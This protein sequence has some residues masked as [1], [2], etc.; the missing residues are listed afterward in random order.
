MTAAVAAYA[1]GW[2][3]AGSDAVEAQRP[4][5]AYAAHELRGSIALQRS[6]AEVALADPD[7]DTAALR[8]MGERVVAACERQERLLEALLTLSRSGRGLR[9]EPLDLAETAAEVLR[10]HDH[11]GLRRTTTLEPARTTGDP[12]L[13]ERLVANLVA[14]AVA[15][16]VPGGRLDVATHTAAGRAVF[17]IANTGPPIPTREL[18]RLFQPFQQLDSQPG[19]SAFGVG[20]GLAIVQ[21]IADAHHAWVSAHAR[22]GGGLGID[23]A[24]PSLD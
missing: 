20:L 14:N 10:A 23:V 15:H 18:D 4:F 13:V 19:S 1:R 21:A 24:F 12:Q 8:E 5:L 17:T 16:N 6:L 9:R 7:A 3:A 11:H 2:N 22:T